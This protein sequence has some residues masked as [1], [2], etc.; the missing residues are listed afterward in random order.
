MLLSTTASLQADRKNDSYTF[1]LTQGNTVRSFGGHYNFSAK[2]FS[3]SVTHAAINGE[4]KRLSLSLV[5]T[6][7]AAQ[8]AIPDFVNLIKI[9]TTRYAPMEERIKATKASLEAAWQPLE[10]TPRSLLADVLTVLGLE[11]E[12]PPLPEEAPEE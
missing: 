4:N 11:Q 9:D 6:P 7:E 1:T 2:A 8:P 5:A 12:I 3:L 10:I